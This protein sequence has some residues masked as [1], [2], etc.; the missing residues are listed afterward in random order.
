MTCVNML[1][2]WFTALPPSM[3]ASLFKELLPLLSD[4]L[5]I[6]KGPDERKNED[7]TTKMYH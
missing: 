7:G 1:E 2:E 4:Y 5:V 6:E 3:T